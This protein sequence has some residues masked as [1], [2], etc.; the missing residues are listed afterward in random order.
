[1]PKSGN[2]MEFLGTD[3]EN[4]MCN[5]METLFG[6]CLEAYYTLMIVFF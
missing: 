1:M 6:I 4:I 2:F 3:E 5:I